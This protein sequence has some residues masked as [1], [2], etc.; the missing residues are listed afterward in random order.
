MKTR[1]LTAILL[2]ILFLLPAIPTNAAKTK[3]INPWQQW[4]DE[5]DPIMSSQER[6]VAR[7]LQTLEERKQFQDLFWKARNPSPHNPENKY[8]IE[9]YRRLDYARKKLDGVNSDRGRIYILLGK[10]FRIESFSGE[11]NVV[12]CELWEYRTEGQHG[13]F[14]FM[15][16]IFYK[17]RDMG[18]YQLYQPGIHNATELLSPYL[19]N[20]TMN[21]NQAFQQVKMSS[22]ELA[23]A[24]LSIVAGEGEPGMDT[25]L[26]SSSMALSKV[27]SLPEREAEVGYIR[28][29]T[30][31]SGNVEVAHS[32]NAVRGYGYLSITRNQNMTFLNYAVMP[33]TLS[34]KYMADKQY[35]AD[36]TVDINIENESGK[37]IYQ[38]ERKVELKVDPEKKTGNRPA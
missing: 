7:M 3:E 21:P 16:F 14:P 23:Q 31:P 29:F 15:N 19:A 10:P 4:L 9:Y 25:S 27:Y 36:I 18:N 5:V 24:S 6:S 8:K 26:S 28:T 34:M 13:L 17:P 1:N 38:N 22:A 33:E 20:N 32:T 12:D 35:A 30:S 37:L 11:K 2:C